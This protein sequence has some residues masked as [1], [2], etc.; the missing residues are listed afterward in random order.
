MKQARADDAGTGAGHRRGGPGL[1]ERVMRWDG[2]YLVP[3][4]DG[5]WAPVALTALPAD[6]TYETGQAMLTAAAETLAGDPEQLPAAT[7]Q[8]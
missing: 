6:G 4:G 8:P 1:A 2:G 5:T 3:R 7:C